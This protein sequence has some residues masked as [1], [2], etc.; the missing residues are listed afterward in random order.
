[1]PFVAGPKHAHDKSKM[2]D[3]R[4]LGEIDNSPYLG[5]GSTERQEI[6]HG[7]A[8]SAFNPVDR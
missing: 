6:F 2:A 5:N 8:R 1:M 4:H 7:D 3:G